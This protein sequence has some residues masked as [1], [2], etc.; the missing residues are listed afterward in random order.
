MQVLVARVPAAID[1]V[2]AQIAMAQPAGFPQGM[3][4]SIFAGLRQQ[5][6]AWDMGLQAGL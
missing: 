6:R 2:Q 4:E 3:T 5:A 1:A